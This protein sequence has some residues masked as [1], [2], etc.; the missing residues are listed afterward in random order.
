M[1]TLAHTKK[2]DDRDEEKGRVRIELREEITKG[3]ST[4]NVILRQD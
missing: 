2:D 3:K 4:N 1:R